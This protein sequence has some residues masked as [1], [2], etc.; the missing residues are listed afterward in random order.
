MRRAGGFTNRAYLYGAEFIRESVRVLQFHPD[1]ASIDD[2][3]A[4]SLDNRDRF[5]VPF[6]PATVNVVGTVYN[7]N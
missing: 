1:S 6:K 3:P 4:I 2:L 7:Q 5:V